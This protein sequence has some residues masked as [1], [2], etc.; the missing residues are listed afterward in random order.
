MA[1]THK[2]ETL[3]KYVDTLDTLFITNVWL[4][5]LSDFL[6]SPAP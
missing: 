3:F 6:K 1:K 4:E 2:I 5:L